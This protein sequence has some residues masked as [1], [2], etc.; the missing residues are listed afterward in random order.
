MPMS[1]LFLLA[2]L[3]T[4][5]A[6]WPCRAQESAPKEIVPNI[7]PPQAEAPP[8][9]AAACP[10]GGCCEA[11]GRLDYRVIWRPEVTPV[12]SIHGEDIV[13]LTHFK[14]LRVV[15][16]PERRLVTVYVIKSKEVERTVPVTHMV[17]CVVKDP[18]T[19]ECHTECQPVTEMKVVKDT[20][21]YSTPVEKEI[22]VPTS[23]VEEFDDVVPRKVTVLGWGVDLVKHEVPI[24][25][26]PLEV[27]PNQVFLLP[28]PPCVEPYPPPT[29]KEKGRV[30]KL[31]PPVEKPAGKLPIP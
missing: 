22:F 13:V 4:L 25:L 21:F 3:A 19:G 9:A 28:Q 16:T 5:L 6:A 10:T 12:Q 27:R 26:P 31:P 23:K 15:T 11:P 17:D 24:V 20:E 30:E 1:R 29:V 7:P 2:G 18:A 8:Q 14:S